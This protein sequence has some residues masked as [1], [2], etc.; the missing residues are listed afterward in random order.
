[1]IAEWRKNLKGVYVY[2]DNDQAGYAALNAL[3][4]KNLVA[5]TGGSRAA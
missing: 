5:K 3:T 4:L 1:R 2:F